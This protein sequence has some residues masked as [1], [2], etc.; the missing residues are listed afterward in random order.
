MG[1]RTIFKML[2]D[3]IFFKNEGRRICS[4]NKGGFPSKELKIQNKIQIH[5]A[6]TEK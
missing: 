6:E 3:D 5:C 4:L 2:M 1:V